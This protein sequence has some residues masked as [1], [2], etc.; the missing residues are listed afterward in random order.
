MGSAHD[1]R[2]VAFVADAIQ[3]KQAGAQVVARLR[4]AGDWGLG[5]QRAGREECA[6]VEHAK[7]TRWA[8]DPR[9]VGRVP[10]RNWSDQADQAAEQTRPG[11]CAA[12]GPFADSNLAP[13]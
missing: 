1:E 9:S 2:T 13:W 5:C 3:R 4:P 12:Q 10:R 7:F 6:Q 8:I 11:G